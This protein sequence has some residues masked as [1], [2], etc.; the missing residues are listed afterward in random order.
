MHGIKLAATERGLSHREFSV[1]AFAVMTS[2]IFVTAMSA[3]PELSQRQVVWQLW[4]A[5]MLVA[6]VVYVVEMFL[7]SRSGHVQR[8][9]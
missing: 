1:L 6:L 4:F 8:V 9:S 2:A 5:S 7:R 3:V